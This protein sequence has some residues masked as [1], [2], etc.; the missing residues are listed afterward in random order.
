MAEFLKI[1]FAIFMD[2]VL[3]GIALFFANELYQYA[4]TLINYY[5]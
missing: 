3:I 5:S 4:D 2:I 1:A